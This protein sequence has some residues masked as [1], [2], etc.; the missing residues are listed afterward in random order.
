MT[1]TM[2]RGL[3]FILISP[4]SGPCILLMQQ[5]K[6]SDLAVEVVMLRHEVA[7]LRR[8][9]VRPALRPSDRALLAGLSRLI[10]RLGSLGSSSSPTPASLASRTGSS[11][12]GLSEALRSAEDPRRDRS[13]GDSPGQ[14]EPDVGLSPDPG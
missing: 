3:S 4:S 14:R 1:A 8:Q 13:G 6:V 12:V 9:V 10:P 2:F 11:Q 5:S 7:V